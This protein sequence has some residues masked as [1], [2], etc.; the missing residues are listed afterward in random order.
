[1]CAA[2]GRWW[3][4]VRDALMCMALVECSTSGHLAHL[5]LHDVMHFLIFLPGP[6]NIS[7]A[8][9]GARGE[10]RTAAVLDVPWASAP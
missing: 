2:V 5:P 6:F 3:Q 7:P 4:A 8:E 1:M 9:D 10:H